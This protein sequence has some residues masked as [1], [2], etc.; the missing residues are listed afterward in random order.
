MKRR[1]A[2]LGLA[3]ICVATWWLIQAGKPTLTVRDATPSAR[4]PT[5][6]VIV[7]PDSQSHRTSAE[8]DHSH[9]APEA[10]DFHSP[11]DFR[12]RDFWFVAPT[13]VDGKFP[14]RATPMEIDAS[15]DNR[16][17]LNAPSLE[18]AVQQMLAL[19]VREVTPETILL[20]EI[21]QFWQFGN[22]YFQLSGR[23]D[24]EIPAR[25]TLSHFVSDDAT[26]SQ[27][28]RQLA[29]PS[30]ESLAA[31]TPPTD[32]ISLGQ[33][34]DAVLQDAIAKGAQAGSRLVHAMPEAGNETHD[35]K[36]NNGQIVSWMFGSGRCQRRTSGDAY[37]RCISNDPTHSA[38]A[39]PEEP[40]RVTD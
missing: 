8:H 11:E 9:H 2:L 6:S 21:A 40:T 4:S 15:C 33:Y 12:Q 26:F 18:Q 39:V 28:V 34:I 3:T 35:L 17:E 24:K 27:N 10:L 14:A 5:P 19:D 16:Q 30:N 36:L 22:Q 37:C 7:S 32:V 29:L 25:Y 23:W 31:P 13:I 20:E 1:L 38:T